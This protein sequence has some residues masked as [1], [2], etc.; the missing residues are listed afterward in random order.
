MFESNLYDLRVR[1]FDVAG[2]IAVYDVY[3]NTVDLDDPNYVRISNIRSTAST[4]Q[5]WTRS[6][7]VSPRMSRSSRPARWFRSSGPRRTTNL[8]C[9]TSLIRRPTRGPVSS[10]STR[11]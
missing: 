11:Q 9:R 7:R 1:V 2:N 3:K 6:T 4:T 5:R 10:T 8:R